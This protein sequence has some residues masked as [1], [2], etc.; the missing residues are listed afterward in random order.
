MKKINFLIAISTIFI[1]AACATKKEKSIITNTYTEEYGLPKSPEQPTQNAAEERSAE[2]L[3]EARLVPLTDENSTKS[4]A[5]S[6]EADKAPESELKTP[7]KPLT[8]EERE[9]IRQILKEKIKDQRLK[10]GGK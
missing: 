5:P 2:I 4:E 10:K 8:E 9:K 1:F 3:P 6:D 7:K